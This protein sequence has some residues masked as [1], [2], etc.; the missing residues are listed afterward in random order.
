MKGQNTLELNKASMLEA[1]NLWL[2]SQF[3][4]GKAPEATDLSGQTVNGHCPVFK[5]TLAS[6]EDV[7]R[8]DRNGGASC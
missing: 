1:L 5:V 7:D 3:A 4:D 2:R 6:S 8:N